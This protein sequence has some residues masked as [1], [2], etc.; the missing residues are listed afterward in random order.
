MHPVPDSIKY[1]KYV[2]GN[3][4]E[5]TIEL[6][7]IS[8]M[9]QQLRVI[10]PRTQYFSLSLGLLNIINHISVSFDNERNIL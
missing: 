7:N 2:I 9:P 5:R 3:V 10:P 4:Y 8:E 1:N 6:W